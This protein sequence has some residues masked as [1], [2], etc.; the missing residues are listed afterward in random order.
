MT[1]EYKFDI[2][3]EIPGKDAEVYRSELSGAIEAVER[4]IREFFKYVNSTPTERDQKLGIK[5]E[6]T[7]L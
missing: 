4:R 1:I 7:L 2:V 6:V 5:V 3:A